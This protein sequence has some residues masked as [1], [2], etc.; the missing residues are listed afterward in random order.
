[1]KIAI[2]GFGRIGRIVARQLFSNPEYRKNLNLVAINDLATP[3][4]LAFSFKYDSTHGTFPTEV[5]SDAES[6][7]VD[8]HKFHCLK[9][10]NPNELPWSKFGVDLVLDCTGRNTDKESA[11]VHL[12]QGAKKVMI[13]A[14]AKGIDLTVVMGVN[15]SL[16][17]NSKHHILSNASCTTNCLAPVAHTLHKHFEIKHGYMTTIHSYTSDQR[18]IDNIHKDPRRARTAAAN[19]IPSTTGA[20]KTVGEVIPSLKGKLDGIAVRVPTPNVSFTDFVCTV[21]KTT[22][23]AEV[24]KVLQEACKGELKGFMDFST[25]PLVSSDYNGN[26]FS[27]IVDAEQT[28]VHIAEDGETMIKVCSWYDNETGFSCRML[29]LAQLV[30]SKL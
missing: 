30:A 25:L 1:M 14:P 4:E 16:Y 19:I 26:K 15:H 24:N 13:S 21:K 18:L 11:S 12:K 27:S 28:S 9:V 7:T 22:T 20:A 5:S 29:D 6:M 17:D 23:A 3:Q 8:G 2:N 10:A